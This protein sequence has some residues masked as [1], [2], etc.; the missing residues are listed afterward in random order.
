MASDS[1]ARLKKS[2]PKCNGRV[3]TSHFEYWILKLGRN[4]ER[5]LEKERAL[6]EKGWKVGT[7]R[8]CEAK[9][10]VRLDGALAHLM[11]R[12]ATNSKRS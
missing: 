10:P 11:G 6:R 2:N 4:V 5:D 3:P 7:I 12:N 9:D 8:E 1:T